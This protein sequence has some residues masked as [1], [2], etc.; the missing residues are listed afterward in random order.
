MANEIRIS[1]EGTFSGVPV[2]NDFPL[3][4]HE[5]GLTNAIR[6]IYETFGDRVLIKPKG[7]RKFGRNVD[8]G[9]SEEQIW[10]TGGSETL[11]TGNTI[12]T[13]VSTDAGDDQTI[14][15]EGHTI[16]G[17]G[18]LTFVTQD[19]VLNGTTAVTLTTPLARATRAY[20]NTQ[21][22]DDV[23]A[24]TVTVYVAA[25][26]THI[27]LLPADQQSLK[28]ATSVSQNDYW[29]INTV[30]V[31][32]RRNTDAIVDFKL[33]VRRQNNVWRTLLP[34]TGARASGT[35][36]IELRTPLIVPKN[37][38]VRMVGAA[39]TSAVQADAVMDGFLALVQTT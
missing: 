22:L 36:V 13:I 12:N 7:L 8:L 30:K 39:S 3:P 38:D 19:A 20:N 6:E 33:Q 9:T 17:S 15:I 21:T 29:L 4:V 14:R 37:S 2:S 32:V 23:F 1:R 35:N 11:P 24:G 34:I 16:D 31:A 10:I 18:N 5:F 25:G 28:A 27:T 26:A